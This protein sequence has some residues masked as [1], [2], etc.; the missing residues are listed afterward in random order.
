MKNINFNNY[1]KKLADSD[2]DEITALLGYRCRIKTCQTIRSR[3]DYCLDAIPYY[4]IFERLVKDESGWSYTAGQS[5]PDEIRAV[6]KI[7]IELR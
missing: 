5:Y 3:L 1:R 2:K 7:I 4:G 6:R